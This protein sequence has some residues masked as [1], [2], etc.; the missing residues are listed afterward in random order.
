MWKVKCSIEEE[1]FRLKKTMSQ[2]IIGQCS[3]E[4]PLSIKILF[5]HYHTKLYYMYVF[6]YVLVHWRIFHWSIVHQKYLIWFLTTIII[7][8]L[9]YIIVT[10]SISDANP[11]TGLDIGISKNAIRTFFGVFDFIRFFRFFFLFVN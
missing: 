4:M 11:D 8:S 9:I 3:I 2:W 1:S 6:I 7:F 5:P 10:S